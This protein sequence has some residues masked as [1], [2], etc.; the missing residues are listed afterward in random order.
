[1]VASHANPILYDGPADI[2]ELGTTINVFVNRV[3]KGLVETL[4]E[5]KFSP[6]AVDKVVGESPINDP[7][8]DKGF[9]FPRP[10][11]PQDIVPRGLFGA[12]FLAHI[13]HRSFTMEL[14]KRLGQ[15]GY[16]FRVISNGGDQSPE[17]QV[18]EWSLD[19]VAVKILPRLDGYIGRIIL[20]RSLVDESGKE[21]VPAGTPITSAHN[22]KRFRTQGRKTKSKLTFDV[23]DVDGNVLEHEPAT[24]FFWGQ[25]G[26][27]AMKLLP[28]E[29]ERETLNRDGTDD[30]VTAETA[31]IKCLEYLKKQHATDLISFFNEKVTRQANIIQGRDDIMQCLLA[32]YRLE[33]I[34]FSACNLSELF[35]AKGHMTDPKIPG[36]LACFDTRDYYVE[37]RK[38]VTEFVNRLGLQLPNK[39]SDPDLSG[40]VEMVE[41][42]FANIKDLAPQWVL[43]AKQ[44]REVAGASIE[45]LENFSKG[46]VRLRGESFGRLQHYLKQLP[47]SYVT[48]DHKNLGD[49]IDQIVIDLEIEIPNELTDSALIAMVAELRECYAKC[50]GL[51]RGQF[52]REAVQTLGKEVALTTVQGMSFADLGWIEEKIA[53]FGPTKRTAPIVKDNLRILSNFGD[54]DLIG[55]ALQEACEWRSSYLRDKA[56]SE[57]MGIAGTFEK[58]TDPRRGNGAAHAYVPIYQRAAAAA[59]EVATL[60]L[61]QTDT[62]CQSGWVNDLVAGMEAL[63]GYRQK[64]RH[65]I[66][67]FSRQQRQTIEALS[68]LA[69][70]LQQTPEAR[71]FDIAPLM[72]GWSRPVY[73]AGINYG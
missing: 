66:V 39:L 18:T 49:P 48:A 72:R 26:A 5:A 40:L 73:V 16:K 65:Q 68:V 1:M 15:L 70:E 41:D 20:A 23:V 31:L 22:P 57:I 58:A 54:K 32:A 36:I 45:L 67:H 29:Q 19:K 51:T 13:P 69:E 6:V 35:P 63:D 62:V 25:I 9:F 61:E 21:I 47:S 34:S 38:P 27:R 12:F 52:L 53:V 4:R 33:Q 71:T 7:T 59:R 43:A 44:I 30:D 17:S 37:L 28:D 46:D 14:P 3:T 2:R 24:N 50:L 60:F 8:N 64:H 55:A 56:Y 42:R 11:R 10:G